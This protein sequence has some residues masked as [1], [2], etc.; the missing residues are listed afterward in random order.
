MI[1]Q[2]LEGCDFATV[3]EPRRPGAVLLGRLDE[4]DPLALGRLITLAENHG[5]AVGPKP[6]SRPRTRPSRR[7]AP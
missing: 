1:N 7:R 3:A 5:E 4:A 2:V 6:P